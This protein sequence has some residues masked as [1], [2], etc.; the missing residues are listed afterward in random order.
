MIEMFIIFYL[1]H[2]HTPSLTLNYFW[3][4]DKMIIKIS[5]I[6][7]TGCLQLQSKPD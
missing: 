4:D 3:L 2:Y 1:K 7:S 5:I 6:S